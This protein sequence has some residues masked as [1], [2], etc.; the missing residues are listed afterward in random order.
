MP[1]G[2]S[3]SRVCR[4]RRRGHIASMSLVVLPLEDRRDLFGFATAHNIKHTSAL[5]VLCARTQYVTN[6]S[7]KPIRA[8]LYTRNN[9]IILYL[10]RDARYPNTPTLVS[11]LPSARHPAV[12]HHLLGL[13]FRD[14]FTSAR[15]S[16]IIR[17]SFTAGL[18]PRV[19]GTF[20]SNPPRQQ[21]NKKRKYD[22]K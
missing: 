7:L 21:N 10:S 22:N 1:G 3:R 9:S 13:F 20:R 2:N 6:I 5:C 17:G 19:S 11:P 4:A 15:Q 14:Y 12:Y 18:Y 16:I 8:V